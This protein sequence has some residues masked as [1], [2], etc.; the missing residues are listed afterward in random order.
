MPIL[1][2]SGI[3]QKG[4]KYKYTYRDN[5]NDIGFIYRD[6]TGDNSS[7]FLKQPN[8]KKAKF[9]WIK[10]PKYFAYLIDFCLNSNCHTCIICGG[11]DDAICINLHFNEFGICAV[12][13]G[14]E[15]RI[16]ESEIINKL[17]A[18]FEIVSLCFDYDKESKTGQIW[19]LK[20]S[21]HY[22]ID[23][24]N[25][26]STSKIFNHEICKDICEMW[27]KIGL[28]NYSKFLKIGNYLFNFI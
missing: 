7:I 15:S 24:I 26:S 12:A 13:V 22:D 11:Q 19:S 27:Q 25:L 28:I 10:K 2:K 14:G 8:D 21:E 17:K 1:S 18:K 5:P 9:I 16:I 20:N 23:C 4:K 3:S 6:G